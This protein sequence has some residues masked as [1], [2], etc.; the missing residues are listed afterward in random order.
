LAAGDKSFDPGE[1]CKPLGNPRLLWELG[2]PFDIQITDERVLFGYTWN[3]LHRIVYVAA[4]EPEVAGPTYLGTS[5]AE[6]KGNTLTVRSA[7]YHDTT[8]LDASGLPHS[9]AMTLTEN[10]DLSADGNALTLRL[11][12]VDDRNYTRAWNA[13]VQFR[14]VPDGRIREDV[15]ELRLGLYQPG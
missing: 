8:L 14:R 15:C 12:I 6:I 4:G 10:Y 13:R 2:W 11:R 7:G 5:H 3:R 9:D 1:Q